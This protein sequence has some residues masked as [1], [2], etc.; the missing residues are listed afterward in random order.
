MDRAMAIYFNML[1]EDGES[2][3]T[4]SYTLFGFNALKIIPKGP[5][6]GLLPLSRSALTAWR[7]SRVVKARL[8]SPPQVIFAFA[9]FCCDC[10]SVEAAAASLIQYDSDDTIFADSKH[11]SF[12]GTLLKFLGH[13]FQGC[14]VALFDVSLGQYEDLCRKFTKKIK[15]SAGFFT[16]HC[17]RHSGPSCDAVH[18]ISW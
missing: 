10:N 11:R 3:N 2:L 15:L 8:G 9:K 17:L 12:A 14:D 6:R 5:E 7:G 16:P 1:F 18:K 4:V 13:K